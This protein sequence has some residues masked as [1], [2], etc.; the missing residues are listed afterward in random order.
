VCAGS[1]THCPTEVDG[2]RLRPDDGAHFSPQGAQTIGG[3]VLQAIL[4]KWA[5]T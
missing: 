3:R 5:T 4:Q 1:V 2:V